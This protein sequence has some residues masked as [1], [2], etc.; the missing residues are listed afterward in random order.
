MREQFGKGYGVMSLG[1]DSSSNFL[2]PIMAFRGDEKILSQCGCQESRGIK[3]I[4]DLIE[5][6]YQFKII[7]YSCY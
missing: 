7:V 4:K 3:N 5:P 2:L 6:V 1:K